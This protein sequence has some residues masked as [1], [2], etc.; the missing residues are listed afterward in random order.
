MI[1]KGNKSRV[2]KEVSVEELNKK[3]RDAKKPSDIPFSGWVDIVKR[4]VKQINHDNVALVSAG[5][6]FYFFLA[7]FPTIAMIFSIYG[8]LTD[9]IEVQQ[10][11][12]ELFQILPESTYE[13]TSDILKRLTNESTKTLSFSLILATLLGFWSTSR[14]VSAIFSGVNVA[15]HEQD[16]RN[17]FK[18][19]GIVMLFTLGGILLSIIC[20]GLVLAAPD[21]MSGLGVEGFLLTLISWLRW[22]LLLVI[23]M[24]CLGLL[25]KY[26][27]HRSAPK[28]IWNSYGSVFSGLVWIAASGGFSYYVTHFGNYDKTYGSFAAVVILLLYFYLT[29]F[30]ILLG[31]EIN[32][33]MEHQTYRDTTTGEP[34]PLGERGAFHAD[35]VAG[36]DESEIRK[37]RDQEDLK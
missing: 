6:A 7:L 36:V 2:G 18:R 16:Q 19:N 30:I 23:V 15:Y 24:A 22:P 13:I 5:V 4:V 33:E 8:L 14:G 32:A 12:N 26:G 3:G 10:Q 35:H 21:I 25:Y 29:A 37:L 9:P 27:P 20:M 11:L 34:Q 17:F 28:W 1:N 31:A